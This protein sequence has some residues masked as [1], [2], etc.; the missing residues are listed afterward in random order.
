M[1]VVLRADASPQIGV[2]HLMRVVSLAQALHSRGHEVTLITCDTN[3]VWI[4]EFLD[5]QSFSVKHTV[6]GSIDRNKILEYEPDWV[7]LDSYI[8]SP[9][10]AMELGNQVLTLL[11]VDD[12]TRGIAADLYLDQSETVVA[13]SVNKDLEA[14]VLRGENYAL[15]RPNLVKYAFSE[16]QVVD[17]NHTRV[18]VMLGGTDAAGVLGDVI[19][20]IWR[21]NGQIV[22]DVVCSEE[23]AQSISAEKIS[24]NIVLIPHVAHADLIRK[25]SKPSLVITAA[26]T[27]LFEF[28]ALGLPIIGLATVQNQL[29]QLHKFTENN[30]IV[31]I[32]WTNKR[33]SEVLAEL[34]QSLLSDTGVRSDLASRARGFIDGHGAE[35]VVESLEDFL[36]RR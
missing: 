18:L 10:E 34:A 28:C 11:I 17:S 25:L 4:D 6:F 1:R 3:L 36:A 22:V 26:G 12:T 33:D 21:L 23:S 27:S 8:F 5:V 7:V 24:E 9:E 20:A 31:G 30:S 29:R 13:F 2:G 32:D 14:R 16:A 35:R 19:E 15:V